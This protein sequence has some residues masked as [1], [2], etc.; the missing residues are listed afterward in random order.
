VDELD[1]HVASLYAARG[2]TLVRTP[3]GSRV[4]AEVQTGAAIEQADVEL[5]IRLCE[6]LQP[7]RIFAVGNAFGYS[8]FVLSY[9]CGNAPL[10][11][12][13]AEIDDGGGVTRGTG[14][15]ARGTAL[16]RR[17]AA[18][19]GRDIRV[20]V[21]FSPLHTAAALRGPNGTYDMA[22]IDGAHSERHLVADFLGIRGAMGPSAV[23]I[24]HDVG[25]FKLWAGVRKILRCQP[26]A[27]YRT[28]SGRSAQNRVGTGFAYWGF[29]AGAFKDFGPLLRPVRE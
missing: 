9:A 14:E 18:E 17:I 23:V 13:D 21:G 1:R 27:Q 25:Y 16:T 4:L 2:Y 20:H 5:V 6:A 24:F 15:N 7:R 29:P 8:S 3:Q 10:D 12:L 26:H 19:E 28:F 11:A 22:F